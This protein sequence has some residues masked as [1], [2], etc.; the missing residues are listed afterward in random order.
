[1]PIKP[2]CDIKYFK[3]NL[4]FF[5]KKDKF[6]GGVASQEAA[7][8]LLC[9]GWRTKME[10]KAMK[11]HKTSHTGLVLGFTMLLA[12]VQGVMAQSNTCK[13]IV[14]LKAPDDWTSAV[15]GGKN[16]NTVK[17]M[18]LNDEGYFQ[19][20][21]ANLGITDNQSPGFAIGNKASGVGLQIINGSKFAFNATNTSDTNWPTNNATLDCPGE[22]NVVYVAEDPLT[23]VLRGTA[24]AMLDRKAFKDVFIA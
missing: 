23:A 10:E 8:F 24:R 18:T 21:L 11:K 14:Y 13:G 7:V 1:M 17:T 16:V 22:G 15:I 12:G 3:K 20:N 9:F 19:Y 4:P 6:Q 5:K 2:L